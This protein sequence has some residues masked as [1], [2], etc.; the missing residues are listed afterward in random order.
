MNADQS[1][2]Q[3][4][5]ARARAIGRGDEGAFRAF[6]EEAFPRL[7][8]FVSRHS[9]DAGLAEELTQEAL[10]IALQSMR[11]YRGESS[12]LSW[13]FGIA[14]HRLLR[15][16]AADA[17]LLR[18]EDDAALHAVIDALRPDDNAEPSLRLAGEQA[19]Q[20]VHSVL[21][22]LSPLHAEC[23]E[24]KYVLGLSVRELAERLGRSE[25]AV[26]STLGRARLAFR[27]AFLA[28]SEAE[29]H[30]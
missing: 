4:D 6:Y 22:R 20:R 10:V 13:L 23:L 2:H 19:A 30:R 12:L 11:N 3:A 17:R 26:E 18:F 7:F 8:R 14:R 9:G 28:G 16:N 29:A 27:D 21:D 1:P 25:K 15:R 5:L 24:G